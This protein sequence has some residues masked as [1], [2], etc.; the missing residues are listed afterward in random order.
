MKKILFFLLAL[1]ITST[2][3]A[4]VVGVNVVEI[5]QI[6]QAQ[7]DAYTPPSGTFPLIYNVTA[8]EHQKWNGSAW[9]TLGS[10]GADGVVSNVTISAAGVLDFTGADGGFNGTVDIP[11]SGSWFISNPLSGDI[12]ANLR[13]ITNVDFLS[14]NTTDFS[15]AVFDLSGN[16]DLGSAQLRAVSKID[17]GGFG[18]ME[19]EVSGGTLTLDLGGGDVNVT[20]GG[21][22]LVNGS[23][24]SGG[25]DNLGNHIA[26]Q[27]ILPNGDGTIDV[28]SGAAQFR[29][30]YAQNG[31]FTNTIEGDGSAITSLTDAN[32]NIGDAGGYFV[33]TDLRGALQEIGAD[34]A[35][36][37]DNLGNHSATTALDMNT[38]D[39]VDIGDLEFQDADA[40][41]SIWF[42]SEATTGGTYAGDLFWQ[43][44]AVRAA[45]P[46]DGIAD[47]PL[48]LITKGFADANYGG[49]T[50]VD[51]LTDTSI[52]VE[53]DGE[54]LRWSSGT[55]TW[56][57]SSIQEADL[58]LLTDYALIAGDTFTGAVSVPDEVYGAGWNGSL[59]VPTKNALYDKIETI[60]GTFSGTIAANQV[61]V[62]SGT[63]AISG[64][65]DLTFSNSKF[66]IGAP[67]GTEA[68]FI[69]SR[70]GGNAGAFV[71]D[72]T[73]A[74]F[75]FDNT[76]V[77]SFQARTNANVQTGVG[78]LVD[79]VMS[80]DQ[81]GN[82]DITGQY[83]VNGVPIGSLSNPLTTDLDVNGNSVLDVDQFKFENTA[84]GFRDWIIDPDDS[85][86][87][88]D[89]EV[90]PGTGTYQ[91]VY[92]LSFT[93]VPV[94]NTDL[95][96]KF[97]LDQ[98]ISGLGAGYLFTP[99]DIGDVDKTLV[100]SDFNK[101]NYTDTSIELTVD[102]SISVGSEARFGG[103]VESAVITLTPDTGVTFY[104]KGQETIVGK[105]IIDSTYVGH[106]KK[107]ADNKYRLAGP[108]KNS[109][110]TC[111]PLAGNLWPDDT[112]ASDLN[113]TEGTVVTGWIGDSS[114]LTAGSSGS[115][116][117]SNHYVLTYS[118]AGVSTGFIS[119]GIT[120]T[121]NTTYVITFWAKATGTL[122]RYNMSGVD[123]APGLT[124]VPGDDTW[125]EY[126][127]TVTANGT[128]IS[129]LMYSSV[130]T[131]GT[132][133]DT[134]E[135]D[136]ISFV[137]Q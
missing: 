55:S 64:S 33:A 8:G 62:G 12:D 111:T 119:R 17:D 133:G 7:R 1:I 20:G 28:G 114:D 82:L 112:P 44:G 47:E 113:C 125:R 92:T 100:Q 79:E 9:E 45:I 74:A 136:N 131:G 115:Y 41:G 135:F 4:Q 23:P 24:I 122:A 91:Q 36:G 29:S 126:T 95:V 108:W 71:S 90:S 56:E 94:A 75:L 127:E 50:T 137:A 116:A 77:L 51:G 26:T 66:F 132:N 117:G 89:V 57:N 87:S 80:L 129:L 110:E 18:D 124:T 27:N 98:A 22:Y 52:G 101:D 106:I 6:S 103:D 58:P 83:L 67:S 102:N 123:V 81:N 69:V 16:L 40:G 107:M 54:Y 34:L 10:D 48:H 14:A 99:A 118:E 78:N 63:D 65:S 61:A 43:N 38:F 93:G 21:G 46:S 70:D 39:I 37:G 128:S 3:S 73:Y 31:V 35:A 19:I 30:I 72:G 11:N 109:T 104:G 84:G 59:E 134:L 88:F 53:G 120:V 86:L 97:T 85:N 15:G 25:G 5:K 68:S 121:D 13:D 60:G 105:A 32:V 96:T 130:N 2:A 42:N 49:A 76:G